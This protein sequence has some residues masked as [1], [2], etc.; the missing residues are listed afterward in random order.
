M[1]V[2]EL[3]IHA[4]AGRGGNG[5]ERWRRERHRPQGGPA[6]GNGGNGGSV[7]IRAVRDLSLLG[8]YTGTKE[9]IAENGE[10]GHGGSKHGKNGKDCVINLPVGV[11]ITNN[12]TG[13]VFVLDHEGQ[14]ELILKGGR[15]GFGNEHF[16]S[17]TNRAPKETTP[18]RSGERAELTVELTLSV[19]VGLIGKPNSGKSTL[20][21]TLTNAKSEVGEYPFTTLEPHLGDLYGFVIAD[22]PGL[23]EGAARGKGLG[24]KFLRHVRRTKMLLH[25][26]SLED[27]DPYKEYRII[28][29]EL[30]SFDETLTEKDEWIILTKSDL[31]N[32]E[33][34]HRAEKAFEKEGRALY[35]TSAYNDT[36]VKHL[37]DQLVEFL[38]KTTR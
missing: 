10:R 25:L 4:R 34:I 19:D 28:R 2:D 31:V 22:I 3:T 6:G 32:T 8:R 7:Y 18:G 14:T 11:A 27:D 36:S 21:N 33:K 9:F 23:I 17:S 1:F 16:K 30:T 13:D 15:G 5:V 29:Q 12:K 35:V 26:V 38:R 37:R 20:I 24:H